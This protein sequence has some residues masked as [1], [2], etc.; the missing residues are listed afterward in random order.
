MLGISGSTFLIVGALRQK[1]S[2]LIAGAFSTVTSTPK[3][4]SRIICGRHFPGLMFGHQDRAGDFTA[5]P[6]GDRWE[7]APDQDDPLS[8]T[9]AVMTNQDAPAVANSEKL[10]AGLVQC[11]A[12]SRWVS[13]L[14][15][16]IFSGYRLPEKCRRI[17]FREIIPLE[18]LHVIIIYFLDI[19]A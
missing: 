14:V 9:K 16:K 18:A 1:A 4:Q 19:I 6:V 13:V 5:A 10:I 17:R 15:L 11:G 12:V 7:G 2:V 8:H 3:N